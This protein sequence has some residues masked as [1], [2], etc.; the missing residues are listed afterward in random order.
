MGELSTSRVWVMRL[1]FLGLAFVIMFFQLLPLDTLPR[2]WAPP[3]LLM[4][5]AFA[6]ALRRPDYVPILSLAAVMLMADLMYQRPPGLM[7]AL[8]VLGC[9][10]LKNRFGRLSD[11]SFAGEWAAVCIVVVAITVLNR[12]ILAVTAVD[13]PPLG[14]VLIQMVM[15]VMIYPLVV[16]V[17]RSLMG[18]RK[19]TPSDADALGART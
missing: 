2:R 7:A 18:V 1:G 16:L 12:L 13:L 10:Y 6:W 17:T 14:L 4:A 3:D 15:T 9:E 5:F 19:L 8:V 11:A